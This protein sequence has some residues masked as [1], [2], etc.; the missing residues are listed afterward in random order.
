MS[1]PIDDLISALG[2]IATETHPRRVQMKSRDFYWYSPILKVELDDV[3]A[4]LLVMPRNEEEVLTV[5]AECFKRRIPVTPRG[6]GTGNYGQ[7]MPLAGG[8]LLDLSGLKQ[9]KSIANGRAVVE[10]GVVLWE[11]EK[12]ARE[13]GR[14]LRM[15]PS[16]VETAS[17]GGFIAGGSAGVGSIHWGGLKDLGNILR[18]RIATMEAEPQLIDLTGPDVMLAHHAYGTTGIITEIELPLAPAH[19]WVDVLVSFDKFDA[20]LRC[21]EELGQADGILLRE[22][23]AVQA[24]VPHTYFKRHQK[25]LDEQDH[26]LFAM[27]APESI[28]PMLH[29]VGKH[30]GQ[31]RYRMDTAT[32]EEKKGVPH[33]FSLGWNHTTL[34]A[35]RVDPSITYLQVG[36]PGPDPIARIQRMIEIF[37][38]EVPVH[39]EFLRGGGEMYFSGLPLVRF[40]TPERLDEIMAIHEA[41]G[42]PNYSPHVSTIEEGGGGHS[43]PDHVVFK[44]R[45]DPEGL[46]NPG[47]MIAWEDP[48]F[49]LNG[50]QRYRYS[51]SR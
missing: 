45:V 37:G 12:A 26:V 38:E 48:D 35:L 40:T 2:E 34:R 14:E 31:V 43:N 1:Y 28:D 22:L 44:R 29:V 17:V 13:E 10:P 39:V 7:A 46:L 20:V 15:F 8:A 23:G 19:N 41:E 50:G 33:I 42:C 30:G 5:L 16:T 36:Y 4:D 3:T 11:L 27:V 47:K 6:S 21:G 32:D 18:L 25:F 49:D 51:V 9:I 24:P